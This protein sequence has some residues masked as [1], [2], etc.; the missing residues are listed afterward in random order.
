MTFVE[1]VAQFRDYD[2]VPFDGQLPR[3]PDGSPR[4]ETLT[5]LDRAVPSATAR[6]RRPKDG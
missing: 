4:V 5:A 3:A 1:I 2:K 6:T